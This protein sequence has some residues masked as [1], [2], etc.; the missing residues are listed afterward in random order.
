VVIRVVV[1]CPDP[2]RRAR[3]AEQLGAAVDM[4]VV[5]DAADEGAAVHATRR[6]GPDVVVFW[7]PGIGGIGAETART[8]AGA[9][10]L[11]MVLPGAR[12][13]RAPREIALGARAIL[14]EEVTGDE[15]VSTVR[16][17]AQT[18]LLVI[19][20]RAKW[21]FDRVL[22]DDPFG[23]DHAARPAP[24]GREHDLLRALAAGRSNADI[25]VQLGLTPTAVRTQVHQLLRKLGVP[26]R[27]QAV[28]LA[29]DSGLLA[30]PRDASA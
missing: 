23:A 13:S 30:T 10:R 18:E 5:A 14:D 4:L 25:A 24:T 2:L 22:P 11:V 1:C 28:A 9:A 12:S 8:L 17:V 26:S 7:H 16:L 19:P 21:Y 3:L 20:L 29:Y 15:L 27:A 6:C